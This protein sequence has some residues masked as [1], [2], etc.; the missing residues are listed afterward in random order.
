MTTFNDLMRYKV[1]RFH[2]MKL[3]EDK[4]QRDFSPSKCDQ[5]YA[6]IWRRC[7]PTTASQ[8]MQCIEYL[9]MRKCKWQDRRFI[10]LGNGLIKQ[11]CSADITIIHNEIK[12]KNINADRSVL[13]DGQESSFSKAGNSHTMAKCSFW[14]QFIR[15]KKSDPLDMSPIANVIVS[16]ALS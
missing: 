9:H 13:V 5:L 12:G 16:L 8:P 2:C 7:D 4:E 3:C 10:V 11:N 1:S 15:R 14:F 6:D